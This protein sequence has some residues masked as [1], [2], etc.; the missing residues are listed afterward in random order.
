VALIINF[1]YKK[2]GGTGSYE[3]TFRLISYA[4][5]PGIFA[6][7]PTLGLI[8]GIYELYILTVGGMIVHNVSK[9]KSAIAVLLPT[10]LVFLLFLMVF[11]VIV[12]SSFAH[13]LYGYLSL[14]K[15]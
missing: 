2:L 15:I 4:Y 5:A 11:V 13:F 9:K 10:I 1:I 12:L 8:T 6:W 7:F 3:G 14:V